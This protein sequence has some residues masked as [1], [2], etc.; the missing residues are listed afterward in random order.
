VEVQGHPV[1]R[2]GG[3]RHQ[4]VFLGKDQ[5]AAVARFPC[6]WTTPD[7][8]DA[9]MQQ[10]VS[11][12]LPARGSLRRRSLPT[13]TFRMPPTRRRNDAASKGFG[14][15][16]MHPARLSSF[17]W[18]AGPEVTATTGI[19]ASPHRSSTAGPPSCAG[20]YGQQVRRQETDDPPLLATPSVGLPCA[21][22]RAHR[23]AEA[24]GEPR[25]SA[26][27]PG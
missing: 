10:A 14:M 7:F 2:Q 22:D 3:P 27:S 5:I 17:A 23:G 15:K 8:C 9:V 20:I 25:S 6:A 1:T 16:A 18:S 26:D 19:P 13:V 4:Q 11:D 21:V 12:Q 24:I